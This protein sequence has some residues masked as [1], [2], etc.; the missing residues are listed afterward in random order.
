M[1]LSS[2]TVKT[3]YNGDGSTASFATGF[4]FWNSSELRVILV[5]SSGSESVLTEGTHY[6]VTG[7]G[8]S[9]G[10]VAATSSG[11][12]DSV[13]DAGEDLV[14]KSN[15]LDTQGTAL[16]AGGAFPST[17]VEQEMDRIVRRIQQKEE[18]L[19]RV[20]ALAEGSTFASSSGIV[21][22]DP[23]ANSVLA[24]SSSDNTVLKN[25][26]PA[27]TIDDTTLGMIAQS[28]AGNFVARTIT[29]TAAE[30]A[31]ADG[32][33]IAGNPT[34]SFPSTMTFAGKTI[35]DLGTVTTA[36]INGGTV[37]G[38]TIGGTT[39]G[40]G[41]F[42]TVASSSGIFTLIDINGGAIDGATIGGTTPG[43]GT[44]TT[45]ASSSAT[46]TAAD[47]NGGEITGI[48]DLVVAD[49]GTGVSSFTAYQVICGGSTASGSLQSVVAGS[50]GQVLTYNSSA[51]LPSWQAAGAAAGDWEFVSLTALAAAAT[52]TVAVAAG[53]DYRITIE[54]F[55]VATD[56]DDI[57]LRVSDDDGV[58]YEADVSDY[59]WGIVTTSWSVDEADDAIELN[60]AA[61]GLNNNAAAQHCL[62]LEAIN[63]NAAGLTQQFWWTFNVDVTG[64]ATAQSLPIRGYGRSIGTTSAITHL[65]FLTSSGGNFAAQGN[66]KVERR[67]R[68]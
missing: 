8:G 30:I 13:P 40:A 65:R 56:G 10:T 41:S 62:I 66:I 67:T 17:S 43:A 16:P 23:V 50:S 35:T 45:V 25:T 33:G 57:W 38:A 24:W 5:S 53:Y 48:T 59:A 14:I 68:A 19:W 1:T 44:F 49:G 28:S 60:P 34:L 63:P 9:S 46:F 3:T 51:S 2:T 22:P 55:A 42:T 61:S 37:D 32:D 29:G 18:F 15:V 6:S 39:R 64:Y 26:T 58:S 54:N 4:P 36:D 12:N 21:L 31:V 27:D 7:G 20:P 52:L 11:A 47:I